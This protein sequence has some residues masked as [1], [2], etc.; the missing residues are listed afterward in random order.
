MQ[1]PPVSIDCYIHLD[2]AERDAALQRILETGLPEQVAERTLRAAGIQGSGGH[3]GAHQSYSLS[4][5][6]TGDEE[7]QALNR[8]YRRQDKATDVL[9]F[10]LLDSPLVVAPTDQLWQPSYGEEGEHEHEGNDQ[11]KRDGPRP[12]F[13]T[14]AELATNL[15]DIVISWPTVNRQAAQA[16]HHPTYE[17]LY[18]LAHGILHL[19]GYD[20]QA[21]AGYNAMVSIQEAVMRQVDWEAPAG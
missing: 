5:V 17:L 2:E 10:P 14:P 18:L 3:G 19:V 8:Q 4:L 15:G 21:E 7:I 6:I 16:G 1:T 20:D 11:F 13:V 9:S 12:V